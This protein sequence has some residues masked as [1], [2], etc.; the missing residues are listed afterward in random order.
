MDYLPDEERRLYQLLE[1]E[2]HG[3]FLSGIHKD[4]ESCVNLERA[5]SSIVDTVRY[6]KQIQDPS[7]PKSLKRDLVTRYVGKLHRTQYLWN[8]RSFDPSDV[9]RKMSEYK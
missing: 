7:V 4:I 1:Q 6:H 5:K 9:L 2:I 3:P 8:N